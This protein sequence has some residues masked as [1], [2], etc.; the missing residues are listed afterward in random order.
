MKMHP[1]NKVPSYTINIYVGLKCRQSEIEKTLQDVENICQKY[2]DKVGQCV[3]ITPTRYVY[4]KG[5]EN[6]AIV[7]FINYPRFPSDK[8]KLKVQALD[9]AHELMYELQQ[10]RVSVDFPE[11]TLMLTNGKLI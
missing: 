1:I 8:V 4:T 6:G 9:L 7:G 10:R 3:T 11:E 5:A 2:V